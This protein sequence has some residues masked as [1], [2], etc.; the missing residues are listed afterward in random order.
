MTFAFGGT[1]EHTGRDLRHAH[2]N[3]VKRGLNGAH[4]D[5]VAGHLATTL[6]ELGVPSDVKGEVMT[7]VSG[8]RADVLGG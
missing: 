2:A 8:V 7:I 3:L 4:F 1:T 6:D 5:A